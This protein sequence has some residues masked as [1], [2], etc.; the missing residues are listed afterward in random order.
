MRALQIYPI[1]L[2]LLLTLAVER[3]PRVPAGKDPQALALNKLR[4]QSK[5]PPKIQFEVGIPRFLSFQVPVPKD[6]PEDAVV[7]ALDFLETYRDLYRIQDPRTQLYVEHSVANETGQHIFFGQHRDDIPVFGAQLAVHLNSDAVIATNGNYLTDI[8]VFLPPAMDQKRAETIALKDMGANAQ[9]IGQVKLVYFARRLFMTPAE[10]ANSRLDDKTH[11]AWQLTVVHNSEGHGYNYFIDAQTG[12]VLFRLNL[13]PSQA[14]NKDFHILTANNTGGGSVFC[15][16]ANPTNWFNQNGKWPGASPDKEGFDAFNF[17][18]QVYDFFHN[19]NP[20]WALWNGNGSTVR[21]GLDYGPLTGNAQFTPICNHTLFGDNMATL[22]IVAH[23]ITHGITAAAISNPFSGGGLTYANQSGALNE[24]YSDVF[25]AMIDGNWTIGEGSSATRGCFPATTY[26]SGTMRDLSKPPAC[27]DP[28]HMSNFRVMTA[29]DGGVHTNSGIPNKVAFLIAAGGTHNGIT[30]GGIGRAK[31]AS[32]YLE[33][34]TT[35]WLT[36]G[37]TFDEARLMTV[38]RAQVAAITGKYGFTSADA[39]VVVNA[40]ASVGLGSPDLDCDGVDDNADTDD[41]GDTIGDSV[42]NCPRVSNPGQQNRDGDKIGDAC[43]DDADNDGVPNTKDNCTLIANANQVDKDNDGLGD[44]CDDSDADG[45]LDS[46]DNCMFHKNLSQTDFD[47]DG[48]GD[49]CDRDADNDGICEKGGSTF[50][51][52]QGVPP[53]GCPTANDNCPRV[54][55]SL[56]E[57]NDRDG[58]GDACDVCTAAN[59]GDTE[60][61]GIDD[62][63]DPDDDNDGVPDANDNCPIL[64]NADQ[65]DI[66][67]NGK[68]TACDPDENL[69]LGLS[70]DQIRGALQFRRESFE[71]YQILILPDIDAFGRRWIPPDFFIE[72][73]VQLEIDLPMRIIDDQGFVVAD[74]QTGREKVLRFSPKPDFFYRSPG[75]SLSDSGEGFEWTKP[76]Q[77]RRYFLEISPTREIDPDR[78]YNISIEATSGSNGQRKDK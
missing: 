59:T 50:S 49:P 35:P 32:L 66:N 18:N 64:A 68:G 24:S 34:L 2:V 57:D 27:G 43:D 48:I 22:D 74:Q 55:N 21:V 71:R 15:G 25:A 10:I 19:S 1:I 26:P 75:A 23:E 67:G 76:Y 29:D 65:R 47:N 11:E 52:D 46:A 14:P 63:C 6:A 40:F 8:P 7:R 45:V 73:R 9:R 39:C 44:V 72:L 60:G 12:A 70:P 16:Y 3:C 61:D 31:T 51:T 38:W 28:D 41:D 5:Q 62:A 36:N 78:S 56:Q 77:G 33:V 17:T 37:A 69:K 13:S 30:V 53:G 54:K 42:D 4:A 20:V 58:Y